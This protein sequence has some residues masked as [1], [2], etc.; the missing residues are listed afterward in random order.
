MRIGVYQF[1]GSEDMEKTPGSFAGQFVRRLRAASACWYFRS[2]RCTDI[3]PLRQ[4]ILQ[5]SI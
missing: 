4:K 3:R 5:R 2:A 1:S